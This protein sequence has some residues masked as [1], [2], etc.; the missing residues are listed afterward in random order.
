MTT[1]TAATTSTTTTVSRTNRVALRKQVQANV[2]SKQ[3][4]SIVKHYLS[5]R[6]TDELAGRGNHLGQLMKNA[7]FYYDTLCNSKIVFNG[8]FPIDRPFG[9]RRNLGPKV[10]ESTPSET[11][12]PV[13]LH[14]KQLNILFSP[15][16]DAFVL[17][18]DC[19]FVFLILA[20]ICRRLVMFE[21]VPKNPFARH[22]FP[23]LKKRI[24]M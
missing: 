16:R 1:T 8:T 12:Y 15:Q 20:M 10:L 13:P 11:R 22:K 24:R 6:R 2:A 17:L 18:L 23:L 19:D 3:H 9:V 14:C 4:Y 21:I 7:S 5:R